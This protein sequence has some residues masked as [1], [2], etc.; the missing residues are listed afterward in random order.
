MNRVAKILV[1]GSYVTDLMSRTPHMPRPGETVLGGP[2][3]MGPGG[4]GGN[5]AVAA[6]RLGSEVMMVTK[7]GYDVF[8]DEAI[9]N[10]EKEN[11]HSAYITRHPTES[12]G[13]ALIAVDEDFENIIV[14][15]PGACGTIDREDVYRAE[16]SFI[17][18]DIVL[19]Q[20]ETS[21]EA[22]THTIELAYEH[23]KTIVLNPAP[24]R[25][26]SD[27]LLRKIDY[28]TPNETEAYWLTGIEV[29]DEK[30]A[31]AASELL[32]QKGVKNVI[33]TLGKLGAFVY[34]A[35]GTHYMVDAYPVEVA[36]TTGA[37]DAF[38]G[39]LATFIARGESLKN[40]VIKSNAVAALAVTKVGTA[41]AMPYEDEVEQFLDNRSRG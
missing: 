38:N 13:T 20:L 40:A 39:G 37:G 11:I 4:K 14:V 9:K 36:D 3:Q 26:I 30:T 16:K 32:I 12:T 31:K 17:E 7:V 23:G 5:Q 22:V 2:F 1:V 29:V 28:I 15:A 35:D 6:A 27:D 33:I 10:F 8:G 25:E 21:L 18:S 34:E 19:L 41:P 24:Y